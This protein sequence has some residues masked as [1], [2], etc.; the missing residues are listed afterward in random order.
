MLTITETFIRLNQDRNSEV[1]A[2][3]DIIIDGGFKV[4]GLVLKSI[5]EPDSDKDRLVLKFP[6][7][8]DRKGIHRDIAH[9][10]NRDVHDYIF[11]EVLREYDRAVDRE[12][13][14]DTL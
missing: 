6:A 8:P 5:R 2:F 7:K 14:A 10:I 4:S 3:A 13:Q 11:D 1:L 9:P 12:K